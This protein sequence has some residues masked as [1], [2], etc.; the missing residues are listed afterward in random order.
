MAGFPQ[1]AAGG[2]QRRRWLFSGNF[3]TILGMEKEEHARLLRQAMSEVG[4]SRQGLADA[5]G[6]AYR[7]VGNW[8]SETTTTMPSDQDRV[9]LRKI[10]GP[11][12][13]PG[14]PVEKAIQRSE[15]TDDRQYEVIGFYKR[16]LREQR[17][18]AGS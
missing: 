7:S 6:K 16:K 1:V 11:Y 2:G 8:I 9:L 12:D 13:Q 10:L 14:D 15:L 4:L 3:A 5:T 18:G 17:E